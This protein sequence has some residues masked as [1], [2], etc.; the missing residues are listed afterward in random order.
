MMLGRW[1]A[2]AALIGL[3]PMLKLQAAP[4]PLAPGWELLS[5]YLYRDAAE[6]F[7]QAKGGD[8]QL[9][10][11]GLAAALLNEPPLTEGKVDR[12]ADMLRTLA[13]SKPVN[14]TTLEARYLLARVR[15]LHQ[16][17]P[18]AEVEAAYRSVI[19]AAP[20]SPVAQVAAGHLALLLLYQRP[21]LTVPQRLAA[22]RALEP[23]AGGRTLP[24]VA[25]TY[26]RSLANAAMFYGITDDQVLHWLRQADA[27]GPSDEL[28]R[29]TLIL[30][31]AETARYLGHRSEA[32]AAYHR[33][34]AEAV[35]T[36]QRYNTAILR[37]K[38]LEEAKP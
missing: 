27:I 20:Q 7:R 23:V 36:D 10:Q 3:A 33:F 35:P 26:Y 25:V 4:D 18:V 37:M 6:L 32:I 1:L 17:A 2:L 24:D 34:L 19:E 13:E 30:Q 31:I 21:D 14:P 16:Q 12:A 28:A 29:A 22:A 15:H 9:R 11:L 8:E 5:R 38:E